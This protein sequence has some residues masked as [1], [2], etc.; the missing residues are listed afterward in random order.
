VAPV[1]QTLRAAGWRVVAIEPTIRADQARTELA[2]YLADRADLLV[3]IAGDGT[4]RELCTGLGE[5][6]ATMPIGLVPVGNANVVARDQGI[7]LAP[8]AAIPLL[9]SGAP[10]R[11]DVGRLR[12]NAAQEESR[13]FLAMVEIG[14]GALV[15]RHA[16]RLRTGRLRHLYRRWGDSLY[17]AAALRTLLTGQEKA[18]QVFCDGD[19]A[20]L[21]ARAALVANTRCYAKGWAVASDAR[22][23]DEWLD[24]VSRL[25][26]GPGILVRAFH[27]AARRRHPPRTF[28]DYRRG[29]RLVFSSEDALAVQMDGDPLP[30]LHWMEVTLL[31][32]R[33]LLIAPRTGTAWP[34]GSG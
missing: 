10:R 9:T 34:S 2:P 20:P 26:T 33:L 7:P 30:P 14:F 22:M 11:L 18:F 15:V 29:R 13:L 27:A 19:E 16:H 32:A 25:E 3:V 8:G 5:T 23:D 31:P 12:W 24:L 1:C 6:A 4:L 21:S 28:S 17:A